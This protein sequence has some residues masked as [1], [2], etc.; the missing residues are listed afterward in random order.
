MIFKHKQPVKVWLGNRLFFGVYDAEHLETIF[1]DPKT[2]GKD[3]LYKF[4]CPIAGYGLFSAPRMALLFN[5]CYK[6]SIVN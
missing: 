2:M 6:N 4:V 5:C 1:N 3:E